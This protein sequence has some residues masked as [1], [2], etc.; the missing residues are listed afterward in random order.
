M[1]L[2]DACLELGVRQALA[3]EAAAKQALA[4]VSVEF[5]S[6]NVIDLGIVKRVNARDH[7]GVI[8]VDIALPTAA[9]PSTEQV[10]SC[11]SRVS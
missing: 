8:A 9:F 11:C 1:L 2:S 7:A 4:G 6:A 5:L 10:C 3:A